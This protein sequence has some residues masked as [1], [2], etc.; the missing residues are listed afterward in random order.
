MLLAGL[1]PTW[2]RGADLPGKYHPGHYVAI[3]EAEPVASIRELDEPP[4][5][6]VNKRYYWSDL[7]PR[8]GAY[9]FSG[10]Q[11]DLDLLRNHQRQ[12]VVSITDKTFNPGR[13][14]LPE[15]LSTYALPNLR[16]FTAKRWD[17]VV[18]SRLIALNRALAKDLNTDPNFEGVALQESALMITPTI[19]RQQ[20][21]TPEKYRDAL[22]QI[23]TESSKALD[24][25]QVFWYMNHLE[26]RDEYLG[27]IAEAVIPY[28]VVMGGPDIL[29]Y[30]K[31]LQSTYRLYDRFNGRL[32]LFGSAQDDSYRHDRN[33]ARNMG[34]A[35]ATRNLPPP[36]AGCV[37]MKE[38]FQF[39][40]TQLHVNYI[41]WSYKNYPGS[42]GAFTFDDALKVMK[43]FPE[44]QGE[45]DMTQTDSTKSP[46]R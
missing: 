37:S 38:I 31:R 12:L 18:V 15:Y 7:E 33:D 19:Q 1:G 9:H 29:P 10:I 24:Q 42:P 39:A 23:L 17:P 43:E 36:A 5:R 6:G 20:D 34:T 11:A 35:A 27:E 3:N 21:Y 25:C 28:R 32:K 40:R 2:L 22:I 26:G 30:R 16:G 41:F 8:Q 14:P 4:V 44:V 46:V 13:N 45:K